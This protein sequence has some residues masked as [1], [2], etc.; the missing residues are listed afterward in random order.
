MKASFLFL[1]S[2]ISMSP[3]IFMHSTGWED[4]VAA[5]WA[6]SSCNRP[7][8]ALVLEIPPAQALTKTQVPLS[9]NPISPKAWK[10]APQISLM[11]AV[12]RFSST[13]IMAS[14][15]CR[16]HIW[17]DPCSGMEGLW[18]A[19]TNIA[20]L[21]F[22]EVG[23]KTKPIAVQATHPWLWSVFAISNCRLL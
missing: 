6:R 12:A 17:V 14:P 19:Q 5:S 13:Q 1:G 4:L 16:L 11:V 21:L 15:A 8:Q 20:P 10:L 2:L 9:L 18:M 3:G 22:G 7:S 23:R